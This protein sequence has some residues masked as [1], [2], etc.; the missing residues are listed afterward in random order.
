M[1]MIV[2]SWAMATGQFLIDGLK[3]NIAKHIEITDLGE[4]HWILG[5]EI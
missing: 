1:L 2:Q 5:I 4:L 3:T